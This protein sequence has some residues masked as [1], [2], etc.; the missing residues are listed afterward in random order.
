M[1][2]DDKDGTPYRLRFDDGVVK[3]FYAE[4]EVS[5]L[6]K[7][8]KSPSRASGLP[9]DDDETMAGK[10]DDAEALRRWVCH[11]VLSILR[12]LCLYLLTLFFFFFFLFIIIFFAA[13]PQVND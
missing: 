9:G 8:S 7:A 10:I 5:L 12:I 11:V 6:S 2:S 1:I 13:P 4:S 3:E